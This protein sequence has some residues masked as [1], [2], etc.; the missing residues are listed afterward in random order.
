MMTPRRKKRSRYTSKVDSQYE[1]IMPKHF[2]DLKK[3]DNIVTVKDLK[4]SINAMEE[5]FNSLPLIKNIRTD[6]E[7]EYL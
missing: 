6:V 4:L 3:E 2:R 7:S 5:K 1:K